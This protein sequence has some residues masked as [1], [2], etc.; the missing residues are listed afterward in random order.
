MIVGS[1]LSPTVVQDAYARIEA[2]AKAAGR[3]LDDLDI[4]FFAKTNVAETTQAAVDEIRMALAAS[5][6]H[7]FRRTL[8]GKHIPAELWEPI[9]KLK[10][11]YRPHEHELLGA[12]RFH[13]KIVDE[14]GLKDY[15]AE[16]FAIVGTPQDCLDQVG[17]AAEA[18]VKKIF[19]GPLTGDPAQV[20]QTFEEPYMC[21]S[22]SFQ[23][24]RQCK[25]H[26]SGTVNTL[27]QP[28]LYLFPTSRV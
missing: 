11:A 18:G 27:I 15:L 5:A 23:Y 28:C 12:E 1:G 21:S 22:F 9:E 13:A 16:R 25:G 8:E 2:G 19:L 26:I 4:W 6:N 24:I 14:L 3:K 10:A 7:A 20:L 17:R